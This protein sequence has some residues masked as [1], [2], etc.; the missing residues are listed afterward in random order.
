M[1]IKEAAIL[2]SELESAPDWALFSEEY[3]AAARGISVFTIQSDRRRGLGVPFVRQGRRV[4]YR[5]DDILGFINGLTRLGAPE[6]RPV[7]VAA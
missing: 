6:A 2:R 5:K 7:E 3:V 4:L 1:E